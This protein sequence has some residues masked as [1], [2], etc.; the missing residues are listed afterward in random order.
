[1][2]L[3]KIF[4]SALAVCFL[5]TGM[6]LSAATL[7]VTVVDQDGSAV[8]GAQIVINKETENNDPSQTTIAT[9]GGDG[10]AQISLDDNAHY[11]LNATAQTKMPSWYEHVYTDNSEISRTLTVFNAPEGTADI[12]VRIIHDGKDD[13][14]AGT[15]L[16]FLNVKNRGTGEYVS[17][18]IGEQLSNTDYYIYTVP[19]DPNNKYN[20][21]IYS[22]ADN[23][24][25]TISIEHAVSG[26]ETDAGTVDISGNNTFAPPTK[27]NASGSAL[28]DV[29]FEGRV[30]DTEED[31]IS[32]AN[33]S[34]HGSG[35]NLVAKTD[36]NGYFAFY[37][38][39]AGDM[40]SAGMYNIDFMKNG[41]KGNFIQWNYTVGNSSKTVVQLQE[42]TG[43]IKG[44]VKIDGVPMPNAW[45]NVWPDWERGDHES[46]NEYE[47]PGM[48]HGNMR[49]SSGIFEM[50]G[51]ASG[52][53][54]LQVW[55]EFSR[56]PGEYNIGASR[57]ISTDDLVIQVREGDN[58]DY[59]KV[60]KT[61]DGTNFDAEATDE[62]VYTDVDDDGKKDVIVNITSGND[63]E[64]TISGVI[65]FEGNPPPD[66]ISNVI[67]I[68]RS[69]FTEAG[70]QPSSGF[71]VLSADDLIPNTVQYSYTIENLPDDT[72][73]LE[74]KAPNFG[75]KFD[76]G[77]RD[78]ECITLA[79]AGKNSKTVN[80]KLAPAGSINVTL[81]KPDGS[82]FRRVEGE[83]GGMSASVNAENWNSGSHGWSE[84]DD[85]GNCTIEG[86]LPGEYSV[87]ANGW[88][89]DYPYATAKKSN[90]VVEANKQTT[91]TMSLKEGIAVFPVLSEDLPEAI[92]ELLAAE[93]EGGG[94]GEGDCGR[95]RLV[96]TPADVTISFK[97]FD[98]YFGD[99]E[100]APFISYWNNQWNITRLEPGIYNFYL[101][102][103]A[104][105]MDSSHFYR[106]IIGKALNVEVAGEFKDDD[107]LPPWAMGPGDSFKVQNIEITLTLGE[108][109]FSGTYK[110]VNTI[111]AA[112][113]RV[114]GKNFD[115]FLD[116]IPKIILTSSDN[117]FLGW[118]ECVPNPAKMAELD[119][120]PDSEIIN[121]VGPEEFANLVFGV[122]W[123]AAQD[124][125]KALIKTQNYP[126]NFKKVSVPGTWAVDMD[127]DIGQGAKIM[128]YVRVGETAIANAAI[129]I[130]GRLVERSVLTESDGSYIIPGLA[131][132][133]YRMVVRAEGYALDAEK[134]VIYGQQDKIVNFALTACTGSI[135]GKVY[136]RKFPYPLTSAGDKVVAYDDTANGENPADE[137]A[138][139]E[140]IT[141][142][143][144]SYIIKPCIPGHTYKV[145]LV[146]PGKAV[147]VYSPSPVIPDDSAQVTGI[148]FTYKQKDLELDI[149]AYPY[150]NGTSV[151]IEGESP[152]EL[153]DISATYNEGSAY[154]ASSAVSI[155]ESEVEEIG[156]DRWR[157]LL[158]DKTKFYTVRF[159]LNNGAQTKK[160]DFVYDPNKLSSKEEDIDDDVVTNGEFL[161]DPKNGDPSGL[162]FSAGSIT[163]G[164]GSVPKCS[165]ER[166]DNESSAEAARLVGA[167]AAGDVYYVNLQMD[168]SQQ[169]EEKSMTLTIGYDPNVVGD[170]I[171][172]LA[173]VQWN[174]ANQTWDPVDGSIMVDPMSNTCSIEVNS[175]SNAALG[176]GN[177]PK[178]V[179]KAVFNGKEYVLSKHPQVTTDAADDQSGIFMTIQSEKGQAY[180]G[181]E[182]DVFNVPNP[183]NLKQKTVALNKGNAISQ[184]NTT[185]TVIRFAVPSSMGNDNASKFRIYNIA[186][187]MVREINVSDQITGGIDGGFHYYIDW[188]G[189]NKDGDKCASGVYFCVTEIG[190]KKKVVKM[191]L[192][193]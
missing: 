171:D 109:V 28:G 84:I 73:R 105:K 101:V 179:A 35:L 24:G 173:V 3:K 34:L 8:S 63:G 110:G 157:F 69:D 137:I 141:E 166:E 165:M 48:G 126:P 72:Y 26:Q 191:A 147:Q 185:G 128:G 190:N 187:E 4:S 158:P 143:D 64:N 37:E 133:V 130:K 121:N 175:I 60:Y 9:T 162:Y 125:V 127:L 184:I 159:S 152:G 57:A 120:M 14:P 182:L 153:T 16:I 1:M 113:M 186:G 149:V 81:I 17:F 155:S 66:P 36:D 142:S 111:R 82:I 178:R 89:R 39:T 2:G 164:E 15:R 135:K 61:S 20:L 160:I 140:A 76:G 107:Y 30:E 79:T 134:V 38:N 83:G 78:N 87:S 97:N 96:Y 50:T 150:A 94:D 58:G 13:T 51:I 67:I 71:A 118:A 80:I 174:A 86:L 192:I 106:T 136:T 74:V 122:H 138:L 123:L 156:S 75:M 188:D 193:K 148:D 68:A 146:V 98:D 7:T 40:F 65:S 32:D 18:G 170:N 102:F 6:N 47:R 176:S 11:G 41:Y 129:S 114:I 169:N 91:V 172:K 56:E 145:A 12:K 90:V 44:I 151:A 177:A 124:N 25:T 88:G 108:E 167:D 70:E 104:E 49:T 53:Y 168:G 22:P 29:V 100:N 92:Q 117:E 119:Q 154:D 52:R 46:V 144:G 180:T 116:Y 85:G 10:T 54:N 99:D 115:R 45:V 181:T 132:G 163:L 189:K 95:M 112:D 19:V 62:T 27:Q 33:V 77:D 131:S 55:T 93:G 43:K 161:L 31:A 59:A 21:D 5:F 42:A 23:K 183:F 103:S 139:Y